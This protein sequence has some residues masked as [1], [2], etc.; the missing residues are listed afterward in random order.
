MQHSAYFPF[1]FSFS[2]V[3]TIVFRHTFIFIHIVVDILGSYVMF[4]CK[5]YVRTI[6]CYQDSVVHARVIHV[7]VAIR[8]SF[9]HIYYIIIYYYYFCRIL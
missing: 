9:I 8:S 2:I 7:D 6:L 3:A 5:H 1:T 4:T